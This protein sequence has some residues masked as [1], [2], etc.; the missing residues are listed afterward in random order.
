M[1]KIRSQPSFT[2]TVHSHSALPCRD[3]LSGCG[4]IM[5]IFTLK[6]QCKCHVHSWAIYT[7]QDSFSFFLINYFP[8]CTVFSHKT[9]LFRARLYKNTIGLPSSILSLKACTTSIMVA[10]TL[11]PS[12]CIATCEFGLLTLMLRRRPFLP[13]LITPS[14]WRTHFLTPWERISLEK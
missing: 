13:L 3:S 4:W 5:I 12:A 2:P 14:C 1:S 8:L 10:L 11:T 6:L 9:F 7:Y